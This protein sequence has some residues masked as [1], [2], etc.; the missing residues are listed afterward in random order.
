MMKKL[1]I[2][3]VLICI[4]FFIP[5]NSLGE[6]Q[7]SVE[8]NELSSIGISL[9]EQGDFD[10][11]IEYF[12]KILAIEPNDVITLGNKGAA[13]TQLDRHEEALAL[14]EIAL[15][16]E[17][18]N[19]N[20]LNNMVASL[21]KL[22][23]TEKAL[24]I[25]DKSLENE[26][27]NVEILILKGKILSE[28]KR[29][30]EALSTFKKIL[31]LDPKNDKAKKLSYTAIDGI[32]LIPIKDSKYLGNVVIELHN[33]DG[34]LIS[35]TISDALGYFPHEIT[36]EYL[37]AVPIK[38]I[39]SVNG[40]MY[41]KR[42]FQEVLQA[43]ITTFVGRAVLGYDKLGFDIFTFDVLPH[44]MIVEKGDRLIANW[45]ILRQID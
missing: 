20:I 11:A 27:N 41:E 39:V 5:Q 34:T 4:M 25:L 45:T 43:A 35:V 3:S 29:Y 6:N 10:S 18:T 32:M 38:E 1:L 2:V 21:F 19:I 15:E 37:D 40:K 36:D 22:E 30:E 23:K 9:L 16:I 8:I 13:L 33:S 44:A 42:E 26:P 28:S 7:T 31:E 17:P 24:Q 14:Y 12:D